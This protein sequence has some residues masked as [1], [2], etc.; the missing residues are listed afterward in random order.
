[1]WVASSKMSP[2]ILFILNLVTSSI[3]L[4]Y[5][6]IKM[7]NVLFSCNFENE[8]AERKGAGKNMK[9][10]CLDPRSQLTVR[11]YRKSLRTI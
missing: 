10:A 11:S 8:Q 1:M 2:N 4:Q 3:F 9:M 5:V 7:V 6:G